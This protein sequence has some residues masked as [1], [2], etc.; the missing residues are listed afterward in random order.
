[1]RPSP[2]LSC[3]YRRVPQ[4]P[5]KP[6]PKGPKPTYNTRLELATVAKPKKDGNRVARRPALTPEA[7]EN[8]LIAYAENLAEK[9]LLDG[10]A[11]PSVIKHYLDLGT[12]KKKLE[13]ERL[14]NE[15]KLLEAKTKSIEA[16]AANS[17]LY[18]MVIRCMKTYQGASDDEDI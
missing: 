6:V 5:L 9:Q 4:S 12:V 7:R 14:K 18:E 2:L 15:N 8:Q 13:L 1:M 3:F 17:E 11:S 16:G 10:T